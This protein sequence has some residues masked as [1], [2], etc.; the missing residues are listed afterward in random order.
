MAQVRWTDRASRDIRA[1][2]EYVAEDNPSAA[3]KLVLDL[4]SSTDRLRD[5]PESGRVISRFAREGV[6]EIIVRPYRIAYRVV[7]NEVR[8]QKVQHGAKLL[9]RHDVI[10]E[11]E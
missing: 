3:M 6:R 2:Y 10:E 4:A 8:I 5:F 1:I 7:G 9:R 11:T